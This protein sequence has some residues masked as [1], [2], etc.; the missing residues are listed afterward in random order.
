ME[1]WLYLGVYCPGFHRL[2]RA[3]TSGAM[4]RWRL[5]VIPH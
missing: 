1:K 3:A 2:I 5:T 4:R